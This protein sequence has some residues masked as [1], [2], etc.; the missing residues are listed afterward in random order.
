MPTV[1]QLPG[2]IRTEEI[3]NRHPCVGLAVGVLRNGSL[4]AFSASGLADIASH[5]PMREDTVVRVASITKTFTAIAV[6]QLVEQGLVSLDAPAN[7]YLRGFQLVPARPGWRPATL[8]HLLTHTGG[9]G[10]EV[11]RRSALARDFG[12]TVPAG[13]PVPSPAQYY[14]RG[15]RL[16]AEPGTRFRYTDHGPTT[17]GQL[18][19]DVTGQ[20]FADYL[21]EH[22]FV[23][24]GM[25]DTDLDP[26]AVDR[27]RMATGYRFGVRGVRPV[28]E[29]SW[30]TVGATNAWSTPRDMGR[31]LA[32][33][34]G[35]GANEHGA[36]LRPAT[37][38]EMFAPQYQPDPRIPGMGLGFWRTDVG[39]HPVVEHQGLVPGFDS[40]ILVAPEDGVAVMAFTNGTSQGGFWLPSEAAGLLRSELGVPDP[41]IRTDV[42][43]HPEVW[44]DLCGWYLLPDPV[45]DLRIREF[46]GA[47]LEVF[48]RRG[49]LF[50]RCLT[51]VPTLYRGFALHP[52]DPDDPYAFRMDLFESRPATTRMATMRLV[53]SQ[54]PRAG[55]TGVHLDLMPVSARKQPAATNPRRWVTGGLAA[56]T[57]VVTLRRLTR[58]RAAAVPR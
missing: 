44:A 20:P 45:T 38:A 48:V 14:R 52:D 2:T 4:A 50:V 9:I 13:R 28:R 43:H 23:P 11:R 3:L 47:G 21:R 36:V 26:A 32:A 15:I 29:R 5:R 40:Q 34:L 56:A 1:D 53:F 7:D 19:E 16:V 17:L 22:V 30:V 24:L 42:P 35:G 18:V 12:E 39:G 6:L 49:R 31:Y 55:T 25:V 58:G 51:P 41:G 54:E 57:A 27:S 8:R 37:V 33:L 10:E 46:M